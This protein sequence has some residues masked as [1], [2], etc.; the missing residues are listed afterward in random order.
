MAVA[1]G[2]P[3]VGVYGPTDPGITGPYGGLAK[4]VYV[5]QFCSPC[6]RRPTCGG[7]YFCMAAVETEMMLKAIKDLVG[8]LAN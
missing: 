4:T 3:V 2:T 7:A 1:A 5:K 8:N 6:Y